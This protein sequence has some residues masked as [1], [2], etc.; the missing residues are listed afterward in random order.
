MLEVVLSDFFNVNKDVI[1]SYIVVSLKLK[2][3]Y[4]RMIDVKDCSK[5]KKFNI[6]NQ[7]KLI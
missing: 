3:F 1:T 7:N 4:Y 5:W 6:N 2:P